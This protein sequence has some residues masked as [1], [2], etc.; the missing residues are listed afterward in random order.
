MGCNPNW[1]NMMQVLMFK[2]IDAYA[3]FTLG[4]NVN[5]EV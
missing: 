1:S 2:I 3:L 4:V 5:I